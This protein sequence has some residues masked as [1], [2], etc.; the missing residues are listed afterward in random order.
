LSKGP[1]L[2]ADGHQTIPKKEGWHP[3]MPALQIDFRTAAA[4]LPGRCSAVSAQ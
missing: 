1:H 4:Q 3:T 2:P